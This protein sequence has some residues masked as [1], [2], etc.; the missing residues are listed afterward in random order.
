ML[1]TGALPHTLFQSF[2][3]IFKHKFLMMRNFSILLI[4]LFSCL[5]LFQSCD[6]TQKEALQ[7]G[8]ENSID[9]IELAAFIHKQNPEL[10]LTQI[11]ELSERDEPFC[12][13]HFAAFCNVHIFTSNFSLDISNCSSSVTVPCNVMAEMKVTICEDPANGDLDVGF[14]E[15][16]FGHSASCVINHEEHTDDWECLSDL[17]YNAAIDIFMPLI[18]DFLQVDNDCKTGN[19]TINS[20]YIQEI[21]TYPCE[22]ELPGTDFSIIR[23]LPCGS[24]RACCIQ[25][26]SWCRN[27]HGIIETKV[28]PKIQFGSCTPALP[29]CTISK[30]D[31]WPMSGDQC[32]A[33]SCR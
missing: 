5:F 3:Y 4:T 20:N 2:K 10:S 14:E 26:S 24:S 6:K 29:P 13:P 28:G 16:V 23:L 31:T 12:A 17:V 30:G 18:L 8:A 19:T 33:R 7:A 27:E 21:C 1:H 9:P 25:K 15:S 32:A 11:T 22:E